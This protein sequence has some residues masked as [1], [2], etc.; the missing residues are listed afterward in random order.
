MVQHFGIP[1]WF[2]TLSTADMQWP[3]VIQ[4]MAHQYRKKL[5]CISDPIALADIRTLS[6]FLVF[7][8]FMAALYLYLLVDFLYLLY[9]T[10]WYSIP[11]VFVVQPCTQPPGI[12]LYFLDVIYFIELWR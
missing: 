12:S 6:A 7:M 8:C 10:H 2:V 5:T 3:E 4:S 9:L 1:T 11:D